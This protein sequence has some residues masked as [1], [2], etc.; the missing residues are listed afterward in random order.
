MEDY[1]LLNLAKK[2]GAADQAMA[3]AQGLFPKTYQATAT[4]AAIDSARAELA[5][6]ILHAQ[7]KSSSN[8]CSTSACGPSGATVNTPAA[9]ADSGGGGC[10]TTGVQPLWLTI[11]VAAFFALRRRKV[12]PA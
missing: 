6:L 12:Q 2:L 3:I 4:P 7:G 8:T 11:P 9:S 10:S 5:A 1:E